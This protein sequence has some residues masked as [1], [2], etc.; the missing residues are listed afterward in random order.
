MNR[1]P[2]ENPPI[3]DTLEEERERLRNEIALPGGTICKACNQNV[4]LR[5]RSIDLAQFL[6]LVDCHIEAG[7]NPY[8]AREAIEKAARKHARRF[9]DSELSPTCR[10]TNHAQLRHW[11]LIVRPD[12][13][14]KP[15]WEI[16][17]LGR[18][19]LYG[20][21]RVPRTALTYN[22]ECHGF[23]D[24]SDL[25]GREDLELFDEFLH[26]AGVPPYGYW[27]IVG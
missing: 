18:E 5:P 10:R 11:G 17:R 8:K 1:L 22:K 27:D 3:V 19:F 13:M 14:S 2:F 15:W 25:I 21:A 20:R 6:G 4:A 26:M 16:T 12:G 24:G 9:A 23:K 7:F